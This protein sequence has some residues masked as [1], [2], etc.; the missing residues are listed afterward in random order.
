MSSQLKFLIVG[1]EA[2]WALETYYCKYLNKLGF[3]ASIF[4]CSKH[5]T[6]SLLFKIRNRLQDLLIYKDVNKKLI[7]YCQSSK[8]AVVWIFKGVEIYPETLSK[9][10]SLGIVLVNYNPD[11]P[12]IRTSIAHGGKNI[13]L[14][15][16]LYDLHFCYRMDL[17]QELKNKFN[18][19]TALLPFGYELSDEWY[20]EIAQTDEIKKVCFIGTPDKERVKEIEVIARA[21][22]HIDIYGQQYQNKY[23]LDKYD[24]IKVHDVVLEKEFWKKIRQYR[25]QINFFRKHNIGSHNQRTFEVPGAGGILL[26]PDSV[27]QRTF[28]SDRKEIFYYNDSQ[29]MLSSIEELLTMSEDEAMA[30][31]MAA[32]ERSLN[33]NYS[34]ESRALTVYNTLEKL[35]A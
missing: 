27:E 29:S 20:D 18:V 22:F 16:P 28:F 21:G 19:Q 5:Y 7:E 17:T 26:S 8:P 34:Y 14:A 31:R 3:S 32:R 24:N 13:V 4:N 11:H 15:I 6:P 25:V 30:I 35:I 23:I 1:S 33:S 10:R 2:S 12:F 9:L